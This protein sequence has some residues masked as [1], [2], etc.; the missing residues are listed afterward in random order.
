MSG[1]DCSRGVTEIIANEFGYPPHLSILTVETEVAIRE[2]V[3]SDDITAGKT[4]PRTAGSGGGGTSGGTAGRCGIGGCDSIAAYGTI[5]NSLS[6]HTRL[7]FCTEV[8]VFVTWAEP[9][10]ITW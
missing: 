2:P 3:S 6:I 4:Q 1:D 8:M 7:S 5:Y 10:S 9:S